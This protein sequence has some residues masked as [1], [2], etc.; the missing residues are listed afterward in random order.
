MARVSEIAAQETHNILNEFQT[1]MVDQITAEEM[2][3][4]LDAF[5]GS[6]NAFYKLESFGIFLQDYVI[7]GGEVTQLTPNSIHITA[8]FLSH[9][10]FLWSVKAIDLTV[11][12]LND[13][14][15]VFFNPVVGEFQV[16]MTMPAA[17]FEIAT[18][19]VAGGIITN[20]TDTRGDTGGI[21][22]QPSIVID[23]GEWE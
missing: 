19:V 21:R 15:K 23:G 7:T 16:D 20:I 11:P 4:I 8:M 6:E 10:N 13:T 5:E 12:N 9:L 22:F 2:E 1:I 3:R 17:G 18:V 14:Y